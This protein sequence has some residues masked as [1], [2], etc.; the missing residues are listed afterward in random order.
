[1]SCLASAGFLL[2]VRRGDQERRK[3]NNDVNGLIF[4]IV[5]VLY[6]IVVGFVVTS[7]W[8]NVASARDAAQQEA[9]G[10]VQVYW[11]AQAL[12]ADQRET[13]QNLCRQYAQEV[14]EDEWPAMRHGRDPGTAGQV[15]LDRL[16]RNV[17]ASSTPDAQAG[18]LNDALNNVFA[19][20]QQRLNLAR[21]NMSGMMWFVLIAGGMFTVALSCLFGVASRTAHLIM[22]MSLVA[23]LGLLLYASY[24]L[25]YPFGPATDLGPDGMTSALR[26]F[27]TSQ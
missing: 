21:Q 9:N 14:R 5:G 26:V 7:Q 13:V 11:V 23:T 19:G 16:S 24:Q 2:L 10:I 8:Q 17:H 4:A 3:E 1:V 15:L 18:Q 22:I 25:Q 12:P 27:G 6:A 20:R